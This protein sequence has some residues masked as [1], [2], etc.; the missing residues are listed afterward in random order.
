MNLA[1][2][3]RNWI[4]GENLGGSGRTSPSGNLKLQLTVLFKTWYWRIL[5]INIFLP[6][7][8]SKFILL[9]QGREKYT[10]SKVK[11]IP[12]VVPVVLW[13]QSLCQNSKLV[14]LHFVDVCKAFLINTWDTIFLCVCVCVWILFPQEFALG[15]ESRCVPLHQQGVRTG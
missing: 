1:A 3:L 6:S 11:I 13:L 8:R 2:S 7:H 9:V 12:E 14:A 5:A 4:T 15:N 10:V